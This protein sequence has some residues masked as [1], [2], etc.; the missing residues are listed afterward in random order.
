MTDDK[1]AFEAWL[2]GKMFK[3]ETRREFA[4]FAKIKMEDLEW[5]FCSGY[6]LGKRDEREGK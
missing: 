3:E 4:E 2:D 1:K 5:A 6:M